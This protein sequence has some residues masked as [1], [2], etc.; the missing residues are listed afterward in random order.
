MID[1]S[2]LTLSQVSNMLWEHNE[3]LES[4]MGKYTDCKNTFLQLNKHLKREF[5]RAMPDKGTEVVKN[6]SANLNPEY[7]KFYDAVTEAEVVYTSKWGKIDV[8]KGKI[9]ALI[10]ILSAKKEEVRKFGG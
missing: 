5:Y 1:F 3:R 8:L 10:S 7:M 9:D 2:Q 4:W 6:K